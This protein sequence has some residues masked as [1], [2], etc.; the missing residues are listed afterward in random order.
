MGRPIDSAMFF[1]HAYRW[2][3]HTIKERELQYA[4]VAYVRSGY[5]PD[6]VHEY[7]KYRV[8]T[9]IVIEGGQK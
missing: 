3:H 5:I 9:Y 7:W 6:Y 1:A 4:Y 8:L 2:K